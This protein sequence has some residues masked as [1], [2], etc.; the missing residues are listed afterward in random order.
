MNTVT[1]T[2]NCADPVSFG[3]CTACEFMVFYG[4]C[5]TAGIQALNCLQIKKSGKRAKGKNVSTAAF[6]SKRTVAIPG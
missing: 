1:S 2:E 4:T 6:D 5:L 3:A